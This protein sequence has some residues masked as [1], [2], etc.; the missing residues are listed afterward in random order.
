MPACGKDA[1][2]IAALSSNAIQRNDR[3]RPARTRQSFPWKTSNALVDF[4]PGKWQCVD[5]DDLPEVP[6]VSARPMA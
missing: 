6:S 5:R 4:L 3:F 1:L 2:M